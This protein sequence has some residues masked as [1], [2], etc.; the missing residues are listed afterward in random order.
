MGFLFAPGIPRPPVIPMLGAILA[1]VAMT[2]AVAATESRHSR[3]TDSADFTFVCLGEHPCRPQA[4]PGAA[5]RRVD[6]F[7]GS[8]GRPCAYR[9]R[10]TPSGTRKVRVCF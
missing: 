3:G 8:L 4:G 2:G 10:E 5:D 6:P 7:Q 1:S 9:W